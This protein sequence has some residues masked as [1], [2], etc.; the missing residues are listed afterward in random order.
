MKPCIFCGRRAD[1]REH[2]IAKRL[3][4]RLGILDEEVTV[5]AVTETDGFSRRSKCPIVNYQCRAVCRHCNNGWMND[6]E[7]WIDDSFGHLFE[8][9]WP[10]MSPDI[11]QGFAGQMGNLCRW[12][13]KTAALTEASGILNKAVVP[14]SLLRELLAKTQWTDFNVLIGFIA[15]RNLD[16]RLEKGFRTWNG[17]KLHLNQEHRD[18]FSFAVQLNHVALRLIVCPG[19]EVVFTKFRTHSG[20]AIPFFATKGEA[21]FLSAAS[22]TYPDMNSFYSR[23]EVMA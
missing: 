13:T 15:E 5:G 18:G 19:A 1:S 12:M 11:V 4:R 21:A 7:A 3:S 16:F 23:A 20:E 2:V 22:H 8:P 9:T 14:Q 17:G 6:L 10:P